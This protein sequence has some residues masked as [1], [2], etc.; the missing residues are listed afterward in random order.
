MMLV[1]LGANNAETLYE[2]FGLMLRPGRRGRGAEVSHTSG[3]RVTSCKQSY[4]YS[5]I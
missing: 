3:N 2:D 4:N 5:I 1:P